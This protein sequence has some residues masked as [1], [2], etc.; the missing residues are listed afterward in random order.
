MR[1]AQIELGEYVTVVANCRNSLKLSETHGAD[2]QDQFVSTA[3]SQDLVAFSGAESD[4]RS[5]VGRPVPSPPAPTYPF[6]PLDGLLDWHGEV[7]SSVPWVTTAPEL[8]EKIV[9][10]MLSRENERAHRIRASKG[11]GGLDI[12]VPT[13]PKLPGPV[14]DYQVK[15]FATQGYS[16]DRTKMTAHERAA[17]PSRGALSAFSG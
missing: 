15:Y 1:V 4:S 5:G 9:A 12:V 17:A 14:T 3:V 16:V 11:D 13:G 6:H 10:V 2:R 7:M 8:V